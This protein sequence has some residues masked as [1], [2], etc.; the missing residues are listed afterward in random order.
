MM[1]VLNIHACK[2]V[3]KTQMFDIKIPL[4]LILQLIPCLHISSSAL[5]MMCSLYLARIQFDARMQ[6]ISFDYLGEPSTGVWHG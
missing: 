4:F 6:L 3:C 5:W 1:N 2:I